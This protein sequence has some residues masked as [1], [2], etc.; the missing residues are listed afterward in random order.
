MSGCDYNRDYSHFEDLGGPYDPLRD[1]VDTIF[2]SSK[3]IL[4]ENSERIIFKREDR[5]IVLT[6]DDIFNVLS[7]VKQMRGIIEE[8][9]EKIIK[10][11]EVIEDMEMRPPGVGGSKYEEFKRDAEMRRKYSSNGKIED[12]D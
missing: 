12:V 7:E 8:M 5:E 9:K 10:L 3:T 11:E 6:I 1:R 2:I 4:L